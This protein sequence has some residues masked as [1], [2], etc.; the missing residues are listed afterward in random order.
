MSSRTF[1]SIGILLTIFFVVFAPGKSLAQD[2]RQESEAVLDLTHLSLEE[3]VEA[4]ITP[5]NVLGSH[6]HLAGAFMIGYRYAYHSMEGNIDGTRD[7]S[8]SEILAAYP[9]HHTKMTMQMHMVELMY[10][11]TDRFTVMAMLPFHDNWMEHLRRN[12]SIFVSESSGIGDVQVMTMYNLLGNPRDLGHRLVLNGGL[13]FPTGSIDEADAGSILEYP[14]QLGSGTYDFRP[15]VTYLGRWDAWSAGAQAMGGE[16]SRDYKLGNEYR[17]GA[18]AY[19]K[20][21]DW[22]GPS[23]RMEWRDWRNIRGADARIDPT[24]NPA[25]DPNLREGRRMDILGGLNFMVDRGPLEGV[26]FS[27]EGGVPVYQWLRG[28]NLKTDWF[29]TAGVSYTF[30]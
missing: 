3:L 9:V 13:S 26:R 7:V 1:L 28:A 8:A 11:P 6:T 12:G 23:I 27:A 24:R 20:A 5:I 14:M 4:Q 19:Y 17:V 16:N 29:I 30:R 18:W 25:F 2:G 22:F 15:G 10:A 21:F